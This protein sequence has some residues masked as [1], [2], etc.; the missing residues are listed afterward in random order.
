MFFH[1][2]PIFSLFLSK[3]STCYRPQ[4]LLPTSR[5]ST[6]HSQFTRQGTYVVRLHGITVQPFFLLRT[7]RQTSKLS[8]CYRP[9]HLLPTS[10]RRTIHSPF[11]R[12]GVY[13]V[14]LASFIMNRYIDMSREVKI[15]KTSRDST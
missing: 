14:R 2:F 3:L 7:S 6:L 5:R 10:L 4:S 8:T 9:H 1:F 12:Q 11:T 13:T 15:D